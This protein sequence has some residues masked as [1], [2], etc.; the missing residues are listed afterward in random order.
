MEEYC[1]HTF[2][3]HKFKYDFRKLFFFLKKE[4]EE[5]EIVGVC[6]YYQSILQHV[7]LR[8]FLIS[9]ELNTTDKLVESTSL[10]PWWHMNTA[11]DYKKNRSNYAPTRSKWLHNARCNVFFFL[12]SLS[13]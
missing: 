4:E 12:F 10:L 6:C 2:L 9:Y 11:Y 7:E 1:E 5:E 8:N 3:I 13:V